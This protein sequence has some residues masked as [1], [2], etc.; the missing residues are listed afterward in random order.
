[1]RKGKRM[2]V[3]ILTQ[4]LC[5]VGGQD[6]IT[7]EEVETKRKEQEG[8]DPWTESFYLSPT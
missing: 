6:D 3:K 2:C 5:D 8:S 7:E 4:I 1:M